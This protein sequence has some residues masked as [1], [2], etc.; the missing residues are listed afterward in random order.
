M[1]GTGTC[2]LNKEIITAHANIIWNPVPFVDVGLEYM[3]AHRLVLSDLKGDE[4]ALISKFGGEV[5]IG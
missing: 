3:W 4:N 2:G 5:L 1:A